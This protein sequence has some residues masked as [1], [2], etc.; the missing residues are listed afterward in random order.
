MLVALCPAPSK[1]MALFMATNYF[2]KAI[3]SRNAY[4]LPAD[5]INGSLNIGTGAALSGD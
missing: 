3:S 2:P 1:V 5:R 4:R